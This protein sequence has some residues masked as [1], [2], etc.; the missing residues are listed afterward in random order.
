MKTTWGPEG[1][2]LAP[3][4]PV[5]APIRSGVLLQIDE[6]RPSDAA[7]ELPELLPWVLSKRDSPWVT[8]PAGLL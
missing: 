3:Q 1:R 6:R 2:S 8:V 5:G 4:A 7:P